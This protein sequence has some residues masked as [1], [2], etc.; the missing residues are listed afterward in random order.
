[1]LCMSCVTIYYKIFITF[2]FFLILDLV[3]LNIVTITTLIR[4]HIYNL[5]YIYKLP[6]KVLFSIFSYNFVANLE[7]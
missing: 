1:M 3:R 5:T 4:G 6:A 2:I 7:T